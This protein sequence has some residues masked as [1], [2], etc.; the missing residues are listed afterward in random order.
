MTRSPGAKP[1]T[2]EPTVSTV[3]A[4][5]APGENGNG[6][7]VW[8]FPATMRVSR[9]LRPAAATLA[10]TSPGP[11]TGSDMSARTRSAGVP[12][13]WQRIA[14][15]AAPAPRTA[16]DFIAVARNSSLRRSAVGWAKGA[17]RRQVYAVCASLTASRIAPPLDLC[18]RPCG[19]P[20]GG[21]CGLIG[22]DAAPFAHP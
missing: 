5:S 10:T 20:R 6:G 17:Q 8:Y 12:N 2:P 21:K 1:E 19:A 22:A 11:G 13:F 3:P 9:K 15:T 14:F 4:N 18:A 16:N 7:L